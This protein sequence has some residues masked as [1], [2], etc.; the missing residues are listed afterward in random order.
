MDGK[1]GSTKSTA[2]SVADGSNFCRARSSL[3][4]SPVVSNKPFASS[5]LISRMNESFV[6][7]TFPQSE[8]SR[9]RVEQI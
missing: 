1:M 8:S 2:V 7:P 5:L 4:A 3:V 6:M 9:D